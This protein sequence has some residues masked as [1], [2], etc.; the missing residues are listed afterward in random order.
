MHI[1]YLSSIKNLKCQS[2]KWYLSAVRTMHIQSGCKYQ[3]EG[4]PTIKLA[5]KSAERQTPGINKNF[6]ITYDILYQ[7]QAPL[8]SDYN[9][10]LLWAA[11]TLAHFDCL[12]TAEFVSKKCCGIR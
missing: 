5:L 2:I 7:F 1:F 6:A 3:L 9:H 12:I 11:M 8:S 4:S 10:T